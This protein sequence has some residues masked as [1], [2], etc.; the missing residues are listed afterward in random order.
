MAIRRLAV[1]SRT[2]AKQPGKVEK[3]V[4][5]TKTGGNAPLSTEYENLRLLH[6][7]I[8]FEMLATKQR[9]EEEQKMTM[10]I[11]ETAPDFTAHSTVGTINLY[12]YMDDSWLV[13]FS[14]PKD[15]TPVC[16]T[17]LA[18][19]EALKPE[20]DKRNVKLLGLSVDTVEDHDLWAKDI[21]S[22]NGQTP[23][24]PVIGDSDLTVAKLYG[25]LPADTEGGSAGRTAAD[26]Q[27]VRNIYV[28][29]PDKK[30]KTIISYPMSTGRSFDELLRVIDS[31]QMTAKHSVATPVDWQPGEDVIILP[32]LSDE[33]ARQKFPNGWDAPLP[34]M[35]V[36]P[37][38]AQ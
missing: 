29:G 38:P 34:Y 1:R 33:D 27:T 11:S 10:K 25:M 20:F 4:M 7:E 28:I 16:T 21:A 19:V 35:R 14:H 18:R 30:I 5:I 3:L 23:T 15:F 37:Q 17:E 31:L 36:V 2:F 26:N 13:L 8:F 12:D 6:L 32:A 9:K 22:I 24:Y